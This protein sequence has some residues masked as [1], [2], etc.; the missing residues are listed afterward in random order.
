MPAVNGLPINIPKAVT[1]T[2]YMD[3]GI[4]VAQPNPINWSYRKRGKVQRTHINTK[5]NKSAFQ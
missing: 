4:N 1:T 2:L 5:T 3:N